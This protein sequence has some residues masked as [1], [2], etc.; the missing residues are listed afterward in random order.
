MTEADIRRIVEEVLEETLG[1]DT[2]EKLIWSF[3]LGGDGEAGKMDEYEMIDNEVTVEPAL[4]LGKTYVIRTYDRSGK[5]MTSY[6][7]VCQKYVESDDTVYYYIGNI[8]Y[9]EGE[10]PAPGEPT[11]L[12]CEYIYEGETYAIGADWY[13]CFSMGIWE[14][15]TTPISDKYLPGVC[16]P[17]VDLKS[18]TVP[19]LGIELTDEESEQLT[20]AASAKLPI[21]IRIYIEEAV[22][23]MALE[24]CEDDFG[25]MYACE[26]CSGY[27]VEVYKAA[28]NV[29]KIDLR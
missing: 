20:K 12:V 24:Y 16:L 10:E 21:V 15:V 13:G 9:I 19:D 6:E 2:E 7:G 29:W 5:I 22:R 25:V 8:K 14:V 23:S 1:I 26:S 28:D 17:V 3:Q 18:V 4:K 11:V 27:G